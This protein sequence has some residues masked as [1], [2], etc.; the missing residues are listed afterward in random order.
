MSEILVGYVGKITGVGSNRT[1]LVGPTVL[2]V[3]VSALSDALGG[4]VNPRVEFE[5]LSVNRPA[6]FVASE[7]DTTS[8]PCTIVRLFVK[9][10]APTAMVFA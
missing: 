2:R 8:V 9:L 3:L 5:M 4:T 10:F 1:K 7:L 6:A